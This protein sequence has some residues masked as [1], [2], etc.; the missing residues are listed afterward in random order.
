MNREREREREDEEPLLKM[1]IGTGAS[2]CEAIECHSSR[3]IKQGNGLA[4]Q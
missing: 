1:S 3:M 2:A 4:S